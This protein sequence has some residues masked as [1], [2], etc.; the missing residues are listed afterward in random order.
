VKVSCLIDTDWAVHHLNGVEKVRSKLA[1]L[2]PHGL[3][4][5][6]ISLAE[7]YEGVYY[8]RDPQR[9]QQQLESFLSS[10]AVLDVSKEICQVF[11]RQRGFLR[12]KGLLI[13]DFDLLI[14]ATCLH[15]NL[16]LLTNNLR[17][18]QRIEGLEIVSIS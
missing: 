5:S 13:S 6:T 14:A 3:G 8:S 9:S 2:R 10:V 17:H 11:G 16:T 7:L 12:Q 1:E 18:F 15:H 4:L